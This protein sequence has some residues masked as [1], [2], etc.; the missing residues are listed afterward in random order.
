M[1]FKS[2]VGVLNSILHWV[3]I[4]M[5]SLYNAQISTNDT[6]SLLKI[7]ET[8]I[9]IASNRVP[10]AD[11]LL[12]STKVQRLRKAYSYSTDS[13]TFN[14]SLFRYKYHY[15][16][17]NGGLTNGPSGHWPR[18]P[19]LLDCEEF[20]RFSLRWISTWRTMSCVRPFP[21][22]S[23]IMEWNQAKLYNCRVSDIL[24]Q[25]D[26]QPSSVT[27]HFIQH[28]RVSL[29]CFIPCNLY[30][31]FNTVIVTCSC[32]CLVGYRTFLQDTTNFKFY[33]NFGI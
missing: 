8:K 27:T 12:N 7:C 20:P 28:L 22:V 5:S 24:H 4:R 32:K 19:R 21:F 10:S 23:G 6:K 3:D 11:K 18:A 25:E 16:I 13:I 29:I 14:F 9:R 15:N 30:I 31:V 1:Q 33:C 2:H 26:I 17:I